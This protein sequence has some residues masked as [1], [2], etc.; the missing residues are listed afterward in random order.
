LNQILYQFFDL[1]RDARGTSYQ[2]S[3]QALLFLKKIKMNRSAIAFAGLLVLLPVLVFYATGARS[4]EPINGQDGYA[5]IGIVARTQDFLSRFPDSYFGTRFGYILPS[6]LFHRMFG[7]EVGHHLLRFLFL[8]CAALLM[9]I[10]GHIKK[11]TVVVMVILFCLSPIVLVSTFSTYTMSLGALFLLFGLLILAIYD[12][13]DVSNLFIAALS[14]ALLA[15]AWNSHLQLL[16]PSIVMFGALIIDRSLEKEARRFL[17]LVQL[18]IAG[19]IGATITCA[20]G[21]VI[22]GTR[23]GVWNPWAP[24]LRFAGSP[25]NDAFKSSGFEWITWRHYVLLVPLSLLMGVAAWLTEENQTLR[26]VMRRMTLACLGLLFVYVLYQWGM[27]GIAFE[28]FFHSSGLMICSLATFIIAIGLLLNRAKKAFLVSVLVILCSLISYVV[29]ARIETDFLPL[30]L[31]FLGV[32]FVLLFA[33]RL[34]KSFIYFSLV[35]LVMVAAWLTVSSP[36]DFPATT[37]GYRTDPL[38]D[39]A[40]FS[41][42]KH[43]MSRGSV[44]NEISLQLPSLPM[45]SGNIKIWFDPISKYDQLSAPFLWY[46]SA[47]QSPSDLGPPELSQFSKQVVQQ[48]PPK[49][50]V[51][52]DG[53]KEKVKSGSRELKT[54]WNYD[55]RWL[56]SYSS[57]GMIV[58]VALLENKTFDSETSNSE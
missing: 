19:V 41:F 29:G 43:S 23:Y 53:N 4:I 42:D 8:G 2:M 25:I 11:S 6:V 44:L 39:D 24:G 36:H 49:F 45:E 52:L 58:Y 15:M 26:L 34:Q 54:A 20:L 3:N 33:L 32:C 28:T 7:F 48:T 18:G 22:L 12:L 1:W 47:L 56:K 35:S 51:V 16:L 30:L 17:Y 9:R 13:A 5:Y 55:L 10:R 14:S 31:V 50:I 46:K 57:G 38:Y 40:L 21:S 37:G 27:G